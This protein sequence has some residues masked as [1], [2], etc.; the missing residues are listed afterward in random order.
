MRF[1]TAMS[2]RRISLSVCPEQESTFGARLR[3][4]R[5]TAGLTQEELAGRALLT[6]NAISSLERGERKRPY[7]HTVRSLADALGLSEEERAKLLAAVPRQDGESPTA[8][9]APIEPTLPIPPTP[10]LGRHHN[11]EEVTDFL[12]QPEVRLLTL[13]GV[14]GVGKTRLA[15]EAAW[16]AANLFSDGVA[17]VALAPLGD[18]ALVIPTVAQS[19]GLR[20]AEGQTQHEALYAYLR[21]KRF[22][23]VVDNFEHLLE[24][25]PEVAKLIE[26][27]RHL[28]VLVTSRAPLRVRGEQEYP[29][30]PLAL[31]ASTLSPDPE[32]ILGSPSGRLFVER[33][34]A[35]SPSFSLEEENALAVA[36]ICW[37]LAGLPLALEL[38]AAKV[39]FLDPTAL[40]SRLD[41]AL[42]TGAARDLPP[43]QSTM[44][45]TLDWS[46]DLLE[47]SQQE[48]FRQL[49]VFAGGFTLEAAEAISTTGAIDLEEVVDL[50]G[51][52]AEQSLVTVRQGHDTQARYGMLEPVRQ[53]AQELLEENGEAAETRR[54]HAAYYLSLAERAGP[55]LKGPDQV[56]WLERLETE[57]DN[58]RAALSW[59]TDHGEVEPVARMGFASWLFWWLHGHLDEGRRWMEKALA[60]EPNMP[61]SARARLLLVAGTLAQGR[62]DWE[63][64]RVFL[65]ESLAVFRQLDDEEGVAYALAA[66][67]LVDL[68]LKRYERGLALVEESI[69]CFLE[70]GQRWAASPMLSFA[71]AASLS[72]G[73]ISR[74]RQLA[75]KGLSLAREVGARD[76]LYLT[77]QALA[78]VARAE[79]DNE[80]AASL[81][82]EGLTLSAEVEDHSSLAYYL[83]GLAAIA[84]SENRSARAARLWGAA[85]AILETTEIIAYAHAPDHSLYQRQVAAARARLDEASWE[86]AW[87]EGRAMTPQQAV[88]YALKEDEALPTQPIRSRTR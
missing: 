30:P 56:A 35:A 80:R 51:R 27:C 49:S 19:L 28:A 1:A 32:E 5:E 45:A 18:P 7:P 13:T 34:R 15:L 8:R 23:L 76:A 62:S 42:S 43:R 40:L 31:P 22:L 68:G 61:D 12:N 54:R 58:L 41:R 39:R 74:A 82:G 88:A 36:A 44:R 64:A 73:D 3:R 69:D 2:E 38:A 46:Y 10:L 57:L 75:E 6:R 83:Q 84:A 48:L 47:E 70:V 11:L 14:G 79:G 17:F 21:E 66:M 9:V 4:L 63:P 81:F 87:A 65:E 26:V 25:A 71:A 59:S 55:G 72:R 20:E 37:R 24:A 16:E 29:V 53:Y 86:A 78:T 60:S 85:E 33:A 67:G 77:L 50:L 52:L